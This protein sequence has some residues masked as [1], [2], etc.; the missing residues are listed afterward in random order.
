MKHLENPYL[1]RSKF[2]VAAN[3]GDHIH[4]YDHEVTPVFEQLIGGKVLLGWRH[5]CSCGE[6][7]VDGLSIPQVIMDEDEVENG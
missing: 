7:Y 6:S 5:A 3:W 2:M 4:D 1:P